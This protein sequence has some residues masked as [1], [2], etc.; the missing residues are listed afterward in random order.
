MKV[1]RNNYGFLRVF[2]KLLLIAAGIA[3][4]TAIYLYSCRN[5]KTYQ[6]SEDYVMIQE[7]PSML[8]FY[9]YT[10]KDWEAKMKEENFGE[11]LTWDAVEWILRQTG[12]TS[13]ITYEPKDGRR[14]VTREEWNKLYDKLLDLLDE[15]QEVKTS[16][17]VI[18][19]KE[20]DSLV[21]ALGTYQTSLDLSFAEPMTAAEFYIMGEEIIG[22][23]S[24]KSAQAYVK[25]AYILNADTDGITFINRK[26]TYRLDI[27]LEQPKT[28][29]NQV[30]DLVWEDGVIFKVQLKEDR[31][32]GNLNALTDT[33]IEIEGYGEIS[34]SENLPVYKT[35]GTIEQKELTDIVIANMNVE[36]VVA[37]DRVEAILLNEP[38]QISNIRVLL[39]AEDGGNYRSDVCVR[40]NTAYQIAIRD[41]ATDCTTET[42]VKAGELFSATE[43]NCIRLTTADENGEFYL[44]DENGTPVS[45]GYQGMLELRRYPEGY[46]VVNEL[47]VEQYLCAVVPSE[48]PASYET[49]ALK[50]Q[51]VCARSYAYIQLERGDYAAFGAHVDDSTNYQVYNKQ[52]RDEKTSAAVWDTAGL[53]IRYGDQTAEAYYFSTSAG[54]TANGDS[55]GLTENPAYGY[56]ASTLVKEGGGAADLSSDD[57][58]AQFLA[59]SDASCYEASMPYFRWTAEADYSSEECQKKISGMISARKEKTPQDI[60]YFN[61][62]GES[63]DTRKKFG[64]LVRIHIAERSASGAALKLSLEYENG[65]ILVGNEYSIRMILGAGLT[66][67]TLADGSGKE[68]ISVLPSAFCTLTLV[69]NGTYVIRGGGY[70]HGI[71]MSQNGAAAMAAQGKSCE[72]I[73][74]FFFQNIEIVPVS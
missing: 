47:P 37:E 20:K 12:T 16:D 50:A 43:E 59:E 58:F 38:A 32:T 14:I 55:W 51:A 39:L 62:A 18:L 13:Y 31:I 23:R 7:I 69:E 6:Y 53:V 65:R 68:N 63:V 73:L 49:E 42:A 52:D 25:N 26:E 54:I 71:G 4:L 8:G 29:A 1:K 67:L 74:K 64:T 56:L 72:E 5:T 40:A 44:C 45:K 66:S 15:R 28:V 41:S 2:G 22:V 24:L 21:C 11:V 3:C 70:G 35:Y 30:C 9:Y 48:M 17:E 27:A 60:Q 61:A 10:P 34:R 19:E 57:A 46:T 36:Y 33:V